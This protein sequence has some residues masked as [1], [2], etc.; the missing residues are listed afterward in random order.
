MPEEETKRI[1][2]KCDLEQGFLLKG[3]NV[4]NY[5]HAKYKI[6]YWNCGVAECRQ[7]DII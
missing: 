4:L 5:Y 1:M 6:I 3:E 7:V 2:E